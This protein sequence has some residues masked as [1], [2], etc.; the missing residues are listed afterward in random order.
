MVEIKAKVPELDREMVLE[1]DF[2]KDLDEAVVKFG[3]D[4]I[5]QDFV[6][7]AKITIQSAMRSMARGGKTD[8]EINTALSEWKP[9]VARAR[10]VDPVAASINRFASMS[11]EDQ[12]GF[13]AQL[14]AM[15]KKGGKQA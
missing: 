7:S 13:I 4:P 2:G 10:T 6:A 14:L 1:Y 3:K 5:Y 8:E 12:E 11:N 9:G 15:K